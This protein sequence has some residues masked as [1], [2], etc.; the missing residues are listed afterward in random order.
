[1]RVNRDS[2]KN[3]ILGCHSNAKYSSV[4]FQLGLMAFGWLRFVCKHRHG[5]KHKIG[6]KR[7]VVPLGVSGLSLPLSPCSCRIS[8]R[9]VI[10]CHVLSCRRDDP[11]GASDPFILF[12]PSPCR[13]F[14]TS[15]SSF[16][17]YP[18]ASCHVLSWSVILE[19]RF[20]GR[21]RPF[22]TC[23][24]LFSSYPIASSHILSRS[25]VSKVVPWA[26]PT[27]LYFYQPC[28]CRIQSR[29]LMF[30]H[31]RSFRGVVPIFA[32]DLFFL[33]SSRSCLILSHLVVFFHVLCPPTFSAADSLFFL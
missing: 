33:F 3:K 26:L 18:F 8:T 13:P 15:L 2:G 21:H 12:S 32:T 19:C 24:S 14:S 5:Q 30:C 17:F 25:V 9:L 4:C 28:L 27:F 10:L 29:L 7:I 23:L 16:F 6:E 1:M 22:S 31:V 20:H 11:M